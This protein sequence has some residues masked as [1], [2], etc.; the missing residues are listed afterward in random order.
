MK[1]LFLTPRLP[2]PPHR[3]DKLKIWNLMRQLS[4]RHQ[5]V[6]LTFVES[7]S[8]LKWLDPLKAVCEEVHVVH[9]PVWRSALQC[10]A[11]VPTGIPFQVAYFYSRE[12]HRKLGELVK[13]IQPDI[14]HTHLIRMA[15]Y[16]AE[17]ES[18]PTVLDMT[19][20][21]SLYLRRFR[22]RE[23]NPFLKLFLD[24]ELRRV[25]EYEHIIAQFD[26][27][28]VCSDT[29]RAFLLEHNDHLNLDLLPN[30][31]DVDA[32]ASD[33]QA[34]TDPQRIIFTGN[35]SYYPNV[36]GASFLVQDVFPKVK[37]QVPGA[38]LFIVGQKPPR[39]ISSLAGKDVTITGFVQ[40]IRSEYLKS[41]VAVS[42]IRF[43]AGTLNKVLEP[44]ALG[45]PVVSTSIGLEGLGLKIGE[46]ILIADDAD[47]FADAIISLLED[48]TKRELLAGAA[49]KRIRQTFN[50]STIAQGL[51]RIY[52]RL[53]DHRKESRVKT[54]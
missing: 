27:G 9:L 50:W 29:D 28:L 5:I 26:I 30:G 32:F 22:N 20:A 13:R 1:I 7:R 49:S 44:L 2:Y 38:K 47:A 19:D 24:Q 45:I 41:A 52:E 4:A 33:A 15:Q 35:M 10:L 46:E 3:G 18:C 54:D 21:V 23:S 37:R 14:L 40:D 36:D 17:Y 34:K 16:S 8:E 6:L 42:P 31:V 48:P 43:G 53:I 12:M 25:R 39:K 51:E 11:A